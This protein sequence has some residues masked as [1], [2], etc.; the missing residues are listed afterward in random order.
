LAG[1]IRLASPLVKGSVPL[2]D[3]AYMPRSKKVLM[4]EIEKILVVVRTQ[5]AVHRGGV[6]LIDV[7]PDTGRVAVKLSGMCVGCPMS[8]LTL[9]A[10]IE[11]TI[12]QLIPEVSEVV[13]AE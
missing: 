6:D 9:K 12:K 4:E 1:T 11:E 10:G 7:N 2:Y 3:A 5:L 13:A 8:E